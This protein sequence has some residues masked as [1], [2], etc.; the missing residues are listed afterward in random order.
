MTNKN[1]SEGKSQSTTDAFRIPNDADGAGRRKTYFSTRIHNQNPC[2]CC[3]K[4]KNVRELCF[5]PKRSSCPYFFLRDGWEVSNFT[6][7]SSVRVK[8]LKDTCFLFIFEAFVKLSIFSIPEVESTEFSRLVTFSE[9]ST[10]QKKGKLLHSE[11]LVKKRWKIKEN[12]AEK[13]K[14]KGSEVRKKRITYSSVGRS[15]NIH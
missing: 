9:F 6:F 13:R 1:A 7:R 11:N 10:T 14:K 4:A 5:E 3:W 8:K 15:C 12:R 2:V